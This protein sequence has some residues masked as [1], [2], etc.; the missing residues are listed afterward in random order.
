MLASLL[1]V[2]MSIFNKPDDRTRRES[3][4]YYSLISFAPDVFD[5]SLSWMSSHKPFVEE[6]KGTFGKFIL[7]K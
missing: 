4:F 6:L 3:V 7:P 5:Y 2:G 1:L